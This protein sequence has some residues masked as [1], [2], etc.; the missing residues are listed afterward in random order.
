[1]GAPREHTARGVFWW[2][3]WGDYI[4]NTNYPESA[5]PHILAH[6]RFCKR[7]TVFAG[8]ERSTGRRQGLSLGRPG[9]LGASVSPR[10]GAEG[11]R[12]PQEKNWEPGPA[13]DGQAPGPPPRWRWRTREPLPPGAP[14]GR[15]PEYEVP[16]VAGRERGARPHGSGWCPVCPL[17]GGTVS[18]R[19]ATAGSLKTRS[20]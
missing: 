6:T 11:P 5:P 13:R 15:C 1:M 2:W 19:E 8:G 4:H 17:A 20:G 16:R 12:A 14:S 9:L 3:G 10:C 7:N 18:P